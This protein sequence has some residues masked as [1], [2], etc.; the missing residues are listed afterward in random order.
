MSWTD[1]LWKFSV[2][3]IQSF[4]LWNQRL[5]NIFQSFMSELVIEGVV[6]RPPNHSSCC[7]NNVPLCGINM[8][9][10]TR[11]NTHLRLNHP[12]AYDSPPPTKLSSPRWR[13]FLQQLNGPPPLS[14]SPASCL[15]SPYLTELRVPRQC[16][17]APQRCVQSQL[18]VIWRR[19]KCSEHRRM[20][21]SIIQTGTSALSVERDHPTLCQLQ[22]GKVAPAHLDKCCKSAA[23]PKTQAERAKGGGGR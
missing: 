13:V 10:H 16:A 5:K 15:D 3:C 22:G 1:H 23:A 6:V 2:S 20:P 7:I 17:A 21:P 9:K 11:T 18:F 14:P 4:L 19:S 8:S 12:T